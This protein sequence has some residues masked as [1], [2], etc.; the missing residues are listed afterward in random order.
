MPSRINR[1]MNTKARKLF[2]EEMGS[3]KPELVVR[4]RARIDVGRWW[5]KTS[6]WICVAGEELVMLAVGRR[7]YFA[8]RAISECRDSFYNHGT[9]EFVVVPGED[10]TIGK[11]P[12]SPRDAL[13]IFEYLKPTKSTQL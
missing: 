7:R 12:L 2:Q 6:L 11:F 5:W 3:S 9:G 8:R 1:K 13:K 4:S 10:L